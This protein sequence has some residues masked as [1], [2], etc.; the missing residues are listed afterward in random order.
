ML[1]RCPVGALRRPVLAKS[2]LIFVIIGQMGGKN[3]GFKFQIIIYA[4]LA[5]LSALKVPC[6]CPVSTLIIQGLGHLGHV[7]YYIL[8]INKNNFNTHKKNSREG[9]QKIAALSAL[10]FFN[11]GK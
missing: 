2:A 3:E 9:K 7:Y 5:A 8:V 6:S 4:D 11:I 10:F 1:L